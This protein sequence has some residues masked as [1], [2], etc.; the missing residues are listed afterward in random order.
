MRPIFSLAALF[1]VALF[2]AT[3]DSAF[4]AQ[5]SIS[6]VTTT[7]FGSIQVPVSFVSQGSSVSAVQFDVQFDNSIFTI[8]E[9]LGTS[10]S[11]VEK[12][13][14]V[15]NVSPASVR[16]LIVGFNQTVIPDGIAVNLTLNVNSNAASGTYS[17]SL[18]NVMGADPQGNPVAIAAV[19]GTITVEPISAFQ[20]AGIVNGA[21]WLAGPIAPGEIITVKGSSVGTVSPV[22]PSGSASSTSLGGFRLLFDGSPAPLLYAAPGQI[23]AVVPYELSG[24][25][26]TQVQIQSG[27]TLSSGLSMTVKPAVPGI[28]TV[29][30][31]GSGQGAILNQDTTMNSPSNPAAVGSVIVIYATG[32][33]QMIP[34]GVDGQLNGSGPSHP[35]FRVSV[36]IGGIAARV[37]YAG[38][39]PGLIS[40]ILQ[41]NAEIPSD[42][43]SGPSVPILLA[44]GGNLSQAGVTVAIK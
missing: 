21:S 27:Q 43:P 28:F 10:G 35:L 8:G 42:V 30:S 3:P 38:A 11:A 34:S 2:P 19:A 6:N 29:N 32:A 20:L 24:R 36:Q 13:F 41:V 23:N 40:G 39:A 16:Y 12:Q 22:Q 5:L 26:A 44:V 1:V 17:L 33:G 7:P 37:L 4:A 31:S 9:S 15:S 18:A 25:T 14:Y